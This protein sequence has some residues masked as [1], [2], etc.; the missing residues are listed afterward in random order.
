[1]ARPTWQGHLKLSL[2]TC[3]V[4]LYKAT[5]A[6]HDVHF[7][8]VHPK[9]HNRIKM[10]TV[11]PELG[12]V[13]RSELV[14]GYEFKKGQYVLLDKKD[15]DSVKLESTRTID[16]QEFVPLDS[17]DRIYWDEPYYLF[18]SGKTGIEAF[19]VIRQAML[20]QE[21]VALGRLVVSTR[22]RVCAIEPRG[23]A[24]LL[25][26]LRAHDEV[27]AMEDVGGNIKVPRPDRQMLDIAAKII[28][29]QAG[30]FDPSHFTDRYEE[31]L[32]A[33]IAEKRKGRPVR[34]SE[35]DEDAGDGKVINL[36]DA[37]RRS[38]GGHGDDG[39]K[40]AGK[41]LQAHGRA[42]R[43]PSRKR[44]SKPRPRRKAA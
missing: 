35:P 33:L 10:V 7:H 24:M 29:Q 25:T 20:T 23:E 41:H 42:R 36:M 28:E 1:M 17:I 26:T 3:P 43:A 9:T 12:E 40:P 6:A 34:V 8:L 31:A 21:R 27:L 13:P 37:L 32:R 44:A 4:A 14:K 15:I 22:E 18:P 39:K 2:V 11:D 5:S 19:G 30:A 38:L 16:I